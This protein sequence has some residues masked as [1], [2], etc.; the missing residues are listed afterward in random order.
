MNNGVNSEDCIDMSEEQSASM[1]DAGEYD[2]YMVANMELQVLDHFL[3]Q[4]FVPDLQN[5]KL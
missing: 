5:N 4:S 2:L 3:W 1:H